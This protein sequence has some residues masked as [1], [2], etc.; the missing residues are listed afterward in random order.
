MFSHA[1]LQGEDEYYNRLSEVNQPIL[2]LHG[3]EDLVC[4]FNHT[5]TILNKLVN[6]R[7]VKLEGTGHELHHQD[8]NTIIEEI[9]RH[10]A[11]K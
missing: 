5:Q 11:G 9:A 3:T 2:I 6:F 8:W 7:R 1:G 4:H 10:I